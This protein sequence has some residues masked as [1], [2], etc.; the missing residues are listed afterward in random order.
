MANPRKEQSDRCEQF[1]LNG[2]QPPEPE[3]KKKPAKKAAAK[4]DD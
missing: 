2:W 3:P 4:K 1:M